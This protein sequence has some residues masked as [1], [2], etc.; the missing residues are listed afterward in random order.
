MLPQLVSPTQGASV[1][2]RLISDNLLISQEMIHGLHTNPSCKD[3]F[4]AIKTD[5]SKVY[6]R[7][8]WNFLEE[9]LKKMGFEAQWTSWI[10]T[11]VRSVSYTV[12]LNGQTHG[13]IVIPERGIR[14]G[15]P[16]SP[17]LFIFCAEALVYAMNK[18]E[19]DERLTGLRLTKK[20]SAIQHLLFAD[21]SLFL[22]QAT[23]RECS[24]FFKVLNLYGKASGQEIN[25]QK[26]AVT[27]GANIDP[28][29]RCLLAGL[30]GIEKEGGAGTYL[31]L[32]ECFSGSKQYS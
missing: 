16:L 15:D 32:P 8:E 23:L 22:C 26:L 1:V 18:A 19:K 25:F 7:V 30:L 2:G 17:F 9:L 29:K 20:F 6:D 5:M 3:D 27:F 31:G 14:Q 12:F 28:I 10:M 24:E 21:D 11:C 13:H 4:L